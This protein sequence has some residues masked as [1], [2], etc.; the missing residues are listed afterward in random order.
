MKP[1][2]C[3]SFLA[4]IFLAISCTSTK[5]STWQYID[6]AIPSTTPQIF[7]KDFISKS[8]VSE[9][10]SVFSKDGTEFYYGVDT[11]GK[12]EIR[13]TQYAKGQWTPPTPLMVHPT[14]SYNDPFLSPSEDRLYY[15]SDMPRN[16][17]DTIKD[18]DIWYSQ[19]TASGWSAPINAGEKI[20]SDRNEYYI[21]F[22]QEGTLYFASNK[23]SDPKR[24]R[25][26]DI[27][28]APYSNGKFL[29]PIKVSDAIN[30][31]RYEADVF[32]APD[33]SYII[34][35]SARRTGYG[36]GDLYISF[37]DAQGEWTKA[38][39]MG[40]TI[41]SKNHELCPFVTHDGKFLFYTSNQDIYWVST[42][43]FDTFR[44]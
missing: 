15:I 7:A 4:I 41:N 12:S 19:K 39:N 35:C 28:Y 26:F 20:N 11:A 21:S 25:D 44:E 16:E 18:I 32:I 10:G 30:T 27:Y 17:T 8:D 6:T 24:K 31:N 40:E 3:F 13:Y 1:N 29:E 33:E 5:R 34:F 9:Y 36:S 23:N 14:Y 43:I 38:K 42:S 22:T 37:K 2:Y